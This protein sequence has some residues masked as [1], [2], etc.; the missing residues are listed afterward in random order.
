MLRKIA[1]LTISAFGLTNIASGENKKTELGS[2][3]TK[4][5]AYF[6]GIAERS[7]DDYLKRVRPP[8]VSAALKARIIAQ[9]P[10]EGEVKPSTKM[11]AKLAALAPILRY[12]ERSSTTEIKMISVGHA[13]I[14]L[15][16]RAILLV[17]EE[18]LEILTTEELQAATAHEMGHEYF[19]QEYELS[20]GRSIAKPSARSRCV[21]T[22]L[23]SSQWEKLAIDLL[24]LQEVVGLDV[25]GVGQ[26]IQLR[27]DFDEVTVDF[28]RLVDQETMRGGVQLVQVDAEAG[29][30]VPLLVEV[31]SKGSVSRPSKA[32]GK[33]EGDGGLAAAPLCVGD[34]VDL[35][36]ILR[37]PYGETMGWRN[38]AG[39]SNGCRE[40]RAESKIRTRSAQRI[41]TGAFGGTRSKEQ[42]TLSCLEFLT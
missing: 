22:G 13:F 12:H 24:C 40:T 39:G 28:R 31:D 33:V 21:A 3:G 30:K 2:A 35:R 26:E 5:L 19:W 9:L 18:A 15:H 36:H 41:E 37:P 1:L 27:T 16:A 17:S 10:H 38:S 7:L 29:T 42:E 6:Q 32:D 4:A 14:G 20:R 34:G 11:Q 25:E 8:R 23:R